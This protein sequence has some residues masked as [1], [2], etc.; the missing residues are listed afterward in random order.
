MARV[1]NQIRHNRRKDFKGII[2]IYIP[3]Y[4]GPTYKIAQIKKLNHNKTTRAALAT[5]ATSAT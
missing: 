3:E 2:N 5:S 1:I 4:N